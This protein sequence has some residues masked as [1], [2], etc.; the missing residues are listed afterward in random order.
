MCTDDKHLPWSPHKRTPTVSL[1]GQP[2]QC[3]IHSSE[4]PQGGFLCSPGTKHLPQATV[5]LGTPSLPHSPFIPS[6]DTINQTHIP[7][8]IREQE[9]TWQEVKRCTSGSEGK[10]ASNLK[11]YPK[12][13]LPGQ[14]AKG[15]KDWRGTAHSSPPALGPSCLFSF[16][17]ST[18]PPPNSVRT[19]VASGR[20]GQSPGRFPF[21][22]GGGDLQNLW[23][24]CRS[25]RSC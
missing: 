11:G 5:S 16:R 6:N 19:L 9:A 4:N 22:M 14:L 8:V 20:Q 21:H 1:V 10:G 24:P 17:L 18:L 23:G 13:I 2:P 3:Q 12:A 7:L 25:G 15:H